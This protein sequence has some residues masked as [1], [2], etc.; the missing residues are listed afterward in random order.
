MNAHEK[1]TEAI[2]M[3][4]HGRIVNS[5]NLYLSLY[6][7]AESL[8]LESPETFENPSTFMDI[9]SRLEK[10]GKIRTN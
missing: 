2:I 10:D 9:F 3:Q 8:G 5:H 4:S 7:F 1:L 6:L